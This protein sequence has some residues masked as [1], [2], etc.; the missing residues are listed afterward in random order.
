MRQSRFYKPVSTLLI[1]VFLR[2]L[3]MILTSSQG[4]SLRM[5]VSVRTCA[6]RTHLTYI[7]D[8]PWFTAKFRQLRQAKEDAYRKGDKVLNKQAKHTLEKE[9]RVA[10]RNYSDKLRIQF[11]SSNSA[12][13]WIGMKD[14]TSYKTPSPSTVENQQ[15]ADNLNEFYS[16]FEKIPR[17]RL[18]HLSAQ[19]LTPPEISLSPTPAIQISEDEVCQVF[20]KQKRKKA[21]GPDGVTPACLKSCADQLAPIFTKKETQNYRTKW[22][23]ACGSNV[24]GHEVIW[25]TGAGPPEGHHWTLAGFSSVCLQ[26]KWFVDNAV[27]WDY[28]MFCNI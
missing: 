27:N 24:C 11:S 4:L 19:A 23:Q 1:R 8:K 18:E 13:V 21:P 3:Q 6:T 26:G 17:T 15:Q 7:N 28:I 2:P 10:N 9:I 16:R 22:L 12:S 14:I 20:R 25:K 5:S